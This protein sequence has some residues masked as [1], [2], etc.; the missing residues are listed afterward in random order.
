MAIKSA[1]NI[2]LYSVAFG[3]G[4]MHSYIVSPLAFKYLPR[5]EFGN[6][7]NKVF[8]IYFI[9][10][11]AAPILLGVTSPVLSNVAL[12]LLGVSSVAGALNY[13]WCLPTCKRI[14]EE[15][16][17]LIADKKH[18]H[19]VDGETK[20]TDEMVA[21]NKQFGKHHGF[22]SIFNLVSL[23]TLGAYGVL[24]ARP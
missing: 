24:L 15:K 22:S 3:G 7:Q 6:L 8:P 19:V 1:V 5:E 9:G 18:E 21:L 11:A 13:F 2:L 10:Q 23:V 20:P 17:K 14:K 12:S 16:L 4:V